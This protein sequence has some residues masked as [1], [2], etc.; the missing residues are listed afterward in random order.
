MKNHS[1][2]VT[3]LLAATLILLQTASAQL[4]TPPA[5]DAEKEAAY[6]TAIEGR[7]A[8]ILKTLNLTDSARSNTV[9]DVIIAQYR[10]LRARDAAIDAKLKADGKE[11]TYANRAAQLLAESKPLHDQFLAKL[12]ESL[13]PDQIVMVKDKMT[14]GK[15][16]VTFDAYCAIVPG[17]TDAEKAKIT[18][19]LKLAREEA[20]DGG[21]APE[22]SDIFQKYKDQINAYLTASGHDV[23]K[24]FKDWEAKQEAAKKMA[25]DSANKPANQAK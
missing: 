21:N 8:D 16:A 9:H 1:L 25:G 24:A 19:L 17:L 10:T 5:T 12:A 14:Y 11:I 22:K 2:P 23:A 4:S 20:I 15:V 7:T 18:E 6:T 13:T 3:V